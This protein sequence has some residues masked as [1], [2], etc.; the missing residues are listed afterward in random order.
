MKR[1]TKRKIKK[2]MSKNVLL[3]LFVGIISSIFIIGTAYSL[4]QSQ[5]SVKG[6]S[7]VGEFFF[8]D[9]N[10]CSSM[11]HIDNI[12]SYEY[13]TVKTVTISLNNSTSK[14]MS[15]IIFVFEPEGTDMRIN[16]V[17][18]AE[19]SNKDNKQYVKLYEWLFYQQTGSN[20][21]PPNETMTIKFSIDGNATAPNIMRRLSLVNCGQDTDT[22]GDITNKVV[23]GNVEMNLN[24]LEKELPVTL[25]SIDFAKW[26]N[27]YTLK[28]RVENPYD[29]PISNYRFNMYRE[30][31]LTY[32]RLTPWTGNV[33]EDKE[34]NYVIAS[35]KLGRPIQP[36]GSHE[37]Q[38]FFVSD[39]YEKEQICANWG[40]YEGGYLQQEITVQ[41]IA[42]GILD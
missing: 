21:L 42:A 1:R 29:S 16:S 38:I 25:E 39:V 7:L 11:M 37:F 41:V 10:I 35:Y 5:L 26:N 22:G 24:V 34:R 17:Q 28:F 30:P 32:N 6:T 36:G 3:I 4:A 8:S 20:S 33:E 14:K 9:D 2:M 15:D 18:G 19:I 40:C 31:T 27:L 23:N 12:E 13:T